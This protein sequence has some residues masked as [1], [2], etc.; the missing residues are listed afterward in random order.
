MVQQAPCACKRGALRRG[1]DDER[2]SPT[3]GQRG[4][5]F[6]TLR[7]SARVAFASGIELLLNTVRI[8]FLPGTTCPDVDLRDDC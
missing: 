3:F 5:D 2:A 7:P 1:H 4:G 6:S 8:E